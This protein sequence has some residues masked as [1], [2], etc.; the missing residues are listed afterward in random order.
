MM[1]KAALIA[2]SAAALCACGK[3]AELERP[4][5]LVGGQAAR[6]READ[7]PPTPQETYDPAN[8]T[9][10]PRSAPIEGA[11]SDPFG[12]PPSTSQ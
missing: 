1:R 11:G 8:S 6:D 4:E 12:R 5:P 10:S 7:R 3:Q 9:R 2:L